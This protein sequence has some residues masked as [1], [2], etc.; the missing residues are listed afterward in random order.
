MIQSASPAAEELYE[1]Y[2]DAENSFG[3]AMTSLDEIQSDLEEGISCLS[4]ALDEIRDELESCRKAF[5]QLTR[6]M[7]SEILSSHNTQALSIHQTDEELPF[8]TPAETKK[9]SNRCPCLACA[10]RNIE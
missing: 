10:K 5:Q 3:G 7:P 8:A 4:A 9:V 2:M 6:R 1:A